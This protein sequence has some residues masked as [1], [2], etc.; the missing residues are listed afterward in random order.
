MPHNGT[1]LTAFGE[2]A[3]QLWGDRG[4]VAKQVAYEMNSSISHLNDTC[5]GRRN[6]TP[7]FTRNMCRA[8][9]LSADEE[10]RLHTAAARQVGYTVEDYM[11]RRV[12]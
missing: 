1:P 7:Y 6:P 10:V 3:H 8:L 5:H 12:I 9:H 11:Q 4:L 2:L